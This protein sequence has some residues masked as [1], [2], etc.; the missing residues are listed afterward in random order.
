MI[1]EGVYVE[2]IFRNVDNLTYPLAVVKIFKFKKHKKKWATEVV[3]ANLWGSVTNNLDYI[4]FTAKKYGKS[5]YLIILN[6]LLPGEY[7]LT[8]VNPN[9][10]DQKETVISTFA[11]K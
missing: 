8:L 4:P 1:D 6:D 9:A 7:G 2:L 10:L 3:S 5:S 11:V